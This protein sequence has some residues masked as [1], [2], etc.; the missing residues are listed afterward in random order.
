MYCIHG[1]ASFELV[2]DQHNSE[3]TGESV[4]STD[5]RNLWQIDPCDVLPGN[6]HPAADSLITC[7]G[8]RQ[9]R[10]LRALIKNLIFKFYETLESYICHFEARF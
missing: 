7:L 3:M 10:I 1:L 6:A 5:E 2:Y 9:V 8:R 4:K